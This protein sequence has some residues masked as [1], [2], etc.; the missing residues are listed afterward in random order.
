MLGE[1]SRRFL[2]MLV[3][4]IRPGCNEYVNTI[5]ERDKHR[6]T[7]PMSMEGVFNIATKQ[8]R[9]SMTQPAAG[10]PGKAEC[11]KRA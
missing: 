2:P 11:F 5:K 3:K 6:D 4:T 10:A 8:V 7:Q 9:N 1:K